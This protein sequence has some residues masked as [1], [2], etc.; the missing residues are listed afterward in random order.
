MLRTKGVHFALD[1][2]DYP[3]LVTLLNKGARGFVPGNYTN[4]ELYRILHNLQWYEKTTFYFQ[5]EVVILP[6]DG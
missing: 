2:T 1:G 4:A 3:D 6:F 5:G